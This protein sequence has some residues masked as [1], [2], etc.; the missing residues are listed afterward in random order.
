MLFVVIL[1]GFANPKVR[2]LEDLLPDHDQKSGMLIHQ[3]I[4]E[5]SVP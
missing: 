5:N 3:R 2:D 4:E 1:S